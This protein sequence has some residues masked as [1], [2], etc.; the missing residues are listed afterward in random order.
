M[1]DETVTDALLREFLLGNVDDEQRQRIQSLFLTDAQAKDRVL[2]VEQDLIEDYLEGSLTT[3]DKERFLSRFAQTAEQQRKLRITKSI[4]EWAITEA[5]SIQPVPVKSTSW[6]GLFARLRLKPSIVVPVAVTAVIAIVV[7]AV[8][9][10]RRERLVI[11]RELAQL[12]SPASLR[13]TPPQMPPLVLSPGAVR[14]ADRQIEIQMR[15]GIRF[16]E[17]QLHWEP[18]E[19]YPTY[20]A[21]IRRMADDALFTSPPLYPDDRGQVIRIRLPAHS[22]RRGNYVMKLTGINPDGS[23]GLNEEYQFA[24]VE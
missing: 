2:A 12:N 10:S 23:H 20:Q 17:L 4:K 9:L 7:V 24:V 6:S 15:P 3:E 1:K 19:R 18:Q 11:E 14:S 13:E 5:A 22:L 16:V 8:W 21:E